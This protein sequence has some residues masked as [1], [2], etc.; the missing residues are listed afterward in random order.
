LLKLESRFGGEMVARWWIGQMKNG[1]IDICFL[2]AM[3][4]MCLKQF[5]K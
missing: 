3:D 4:A 2:S 1:K 5:H